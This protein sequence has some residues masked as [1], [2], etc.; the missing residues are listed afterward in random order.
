MFII[1]RRGWEIPESAATPEHLFWD[2]RAVI[3][4]AASAAA[5]ALVPSHAVAQRVADLPDPSQD[6]Y[7]ASRSEK[8]TL[9]R[10]ITD[11]KVN[12]TYNNFF[13]FGSAKTIAKQAQ[14]LKIRPWTVK[15][16]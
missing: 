5:A 16:D 2:R 12:G 7:P 13:E 11:E 15:I 14:A 1:R 8:Y 10:P 9:D 4:G 6:L 3:A